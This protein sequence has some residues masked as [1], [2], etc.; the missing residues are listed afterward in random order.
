MNKIEIKTLVYAFVQ[1]LIE[2]IKFVEQIVREKNYGQCKIIEQVNTLIR[3]EQVVRLFSIRGVSFFFWS[4]EKVN[5]CK[6]YVKCRFW[7]AFKAQ[8]PELLELSDH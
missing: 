5:Y 7:P 2:P 6:W 3:R 1:A 8:S 4:L